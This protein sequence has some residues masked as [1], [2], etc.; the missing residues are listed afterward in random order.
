[1][2]N[3]LNNDNVPTHY[4]SFISGGVDPNFSNLILD[5]TGR[6]GNNSILNNQYIKSGPALKGLVKNPDLP[7]KFHTNVKDKSFGKLDVF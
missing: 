7:G 4:R 5:R 1:M 2:G 3:F 6:S